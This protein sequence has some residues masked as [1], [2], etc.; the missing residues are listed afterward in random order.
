MIASNPELTLSLLYLSSSAISGIR[1]S[2]GL[3]SDI[4]TCRLVRQLER[5]MDGFHEPCGGSWKHDI[6]NL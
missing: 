4:R 2:S 1:G 6:I 5:L 3:G